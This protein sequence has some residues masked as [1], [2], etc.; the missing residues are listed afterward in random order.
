MA[1]YGNDNL[2]NTLASLIKAVNT[3]TN[4]IEEYLTEVQEN[5]QIQGSTDRTNLKD[6][7]NNRVNVINYIDP[8]T[9]SGAVANNESLVTNIANAVADAV[10]AA[11]IIE[12]KRI[13]EQN[14][15]I[16]VNVQ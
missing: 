9:L 7:G 6:I 11:L 15:L 1:E 16:N 14:G 3:N 5:A 8:D 10:A 12:L 2:N 13:L 4:T